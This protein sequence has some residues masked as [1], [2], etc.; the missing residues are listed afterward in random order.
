MICAS[1]NRISAKTIAED[2]GRN[3]EVPHTACIGEAE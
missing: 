2:E 1:G 3:S